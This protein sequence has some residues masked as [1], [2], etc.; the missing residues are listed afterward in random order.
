MAPA[1]APAT[2]AA[3]AGFTLLECG[4]GFGAARKRHLAAG[5]C[6]GDGPLGSRLARS[7]GFARLARLP[8]LTRRTRLA[9]W[10]ALALLTR[11]PG[12]ALRL[13]FA[14]FAALGA[15]A[16][17][18]TAAALSGPLLRRL[19]LAT[20]LRPIATAPLIAAAVA[21]A[22]VAPPVASFATVLAPLAVAIAAAEFALIASFASMLTWRA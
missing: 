22:L 20:F 10:L 19:R 1:I 14:R 16:L 17:L 4:H 15:V 7:T 13:P 21:T 5:R 2:T 18:R 6:F 8:R 11:R 12:F 3:F 9:L